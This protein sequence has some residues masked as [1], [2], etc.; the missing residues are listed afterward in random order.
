M[1]MVLG[2]WILGCVIAGLAMSAHWRRCPDDKKP[3]TEEM[4]VVI[5][6]WPALLIGGAAQKPSPSCQPN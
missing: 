5:T 4:V 6:M 1:K 3:T 2:Y